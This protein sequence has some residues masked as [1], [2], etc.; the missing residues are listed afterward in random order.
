LSETRSNSIPTPSVPVSI[1]GIIGQVQ[2]HSRPPLKKFL[3]P[4]PI[5]MIKRTFLTKSTHPEYFVKFY[6]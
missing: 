2:N 5:V 4:I 3:Q 1:T 6:K